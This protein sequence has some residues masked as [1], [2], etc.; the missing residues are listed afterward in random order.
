MSNLKENVKATGQIE[1]IDADGLVVRKANLVVTSGKNWMA[2]MISGVGTKM[3]HIAAGTGV[4]P[5]AAADVALGTELF[6]KAVVTS[7]GVVT[8]NVLVFEVTLVAGEATGA[9]TEVGLLNA[10]VNGVMAAR[11]VFAV[12]NKGAADILNIRWTLTIS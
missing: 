11:S 7:G 4:V 5:A 12:Y 10:A 2:S 6:R 8:D 1:L 3:S 9:L